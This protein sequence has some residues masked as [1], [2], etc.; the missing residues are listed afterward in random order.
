MLLS[1]KEKEKIVVKLANEGKTTREIAKEVHISLKSIGQILNKVTGDDEAEK[2]QRL[3]DKS[4]YAQAFKMF[5]D[6]LPL[7]DVA[8]E[9]DIESQL[10]SVTMR[11]TL[12]L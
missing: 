7:A 2:E 11:T 9:L 3:K 12:S 5:K 8:I 4:E 1:K 10:L 6:G